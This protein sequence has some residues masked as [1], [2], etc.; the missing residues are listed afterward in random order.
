[1]TTDLS[2]GLRGAGVTCAGVPAIHPD[3]HETLLNV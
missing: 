3:A 1:M 2:L